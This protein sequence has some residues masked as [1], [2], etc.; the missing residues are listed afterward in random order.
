MRVPAT[1]SEQP[2]ANNP[3]VDQKI[4][5]PTE[6][7]IDAIARAFIH[8]EQVVH[9]TLGRK[10][11]GS[12]GDLRLLQKLLD[13]GTVEREAT[14]TLQALGLALAAPA[15]RF[16][17]AASDYFPVGLRRRC[18]SSATRSSTVGLPKMRSRSAV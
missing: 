4:E 11:D 13:S 6:V 8:A 18:S 2:K 1:H 17:V 15:A 14:Y 12:R 9:E 5:P 7:D 10:L 16:Y 3:V